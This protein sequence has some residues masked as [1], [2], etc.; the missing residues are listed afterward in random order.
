M[1]A[2]NKSETYNLN[3]SNMTWMLQWSQ[4]IFTSAASILN[5]VIWICQSHKSPNFKEVQD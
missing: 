4:D 3:N 1:D 5:T 2:I